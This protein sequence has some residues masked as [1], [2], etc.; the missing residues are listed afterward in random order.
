MLNQWF[1]TIAKI[2]RFLNQWFRL[3]SKIKSNFKKGR[4]FVKKSR[5]QL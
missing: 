3:H 2:F 1:F 4:F 5:I